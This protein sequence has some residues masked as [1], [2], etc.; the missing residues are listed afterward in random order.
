MDA[1]CNGPCGT[2]DVCRN[3]PS[4][5]PLTAK[6]Q[7]N[8]MLPLPSDTKQK[9]MLPIAAL[10]RI[11]SHGVPGSTP[12]TVAPSSTGTAPSSAY[13]PSTPKLFLP[14]AAF[15]APAMPITTSV[16]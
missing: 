4:K 10:H 3:V 5:D 13:Q 11:V 9:P 1:Q 14:S 15:S 6:K 8:L 16:E 2:Q 7:H 12:C